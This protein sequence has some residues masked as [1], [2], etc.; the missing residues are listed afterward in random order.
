MQ[1]ETIT[2]IEHEDMPASTDWLTDL[3]ATVDGEGN[4]KIDFEFLKQLVNERAIYKIDIEFTVKNIK[5]LLTQLG[6]LTPDGE[7]D[8]KFSRLVKSVNKILWSP[9]AAQKEFNYLGSL[10]D[11]ITRY[12]DA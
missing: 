6:I 12:K 8:F 5:R 3:K 10:G 4:V 9:D 11:V 2:D 1:T 7:L